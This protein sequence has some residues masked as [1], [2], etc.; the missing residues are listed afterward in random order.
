M[1]VKA[2]SNGWDN[3]QPTRRHIPEYLSNFVVRTSISLSI[4]D[5]QSIILEAKYIPQQNI[6][7]QTPLETQ[8]LRLSHLCC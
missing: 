8:N 3:P 1:G 2:Q 4:P 6:P 7:K 5:F